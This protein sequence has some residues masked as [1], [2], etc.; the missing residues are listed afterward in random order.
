M[1]HR[2]VPTSKSKGRT[3]LDCSVSIQTSPKRRGQLYA[4]DPISLGLSLWPLV[5]LEA[6]EPAN[7]VVNQKWL[8]GV[9]TDLAGLMLCLRQ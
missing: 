1:L 2:E 8:A 6:L 5:S 4:A 3:G 9:V 7:L